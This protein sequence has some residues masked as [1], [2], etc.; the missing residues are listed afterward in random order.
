MK[1]IVRFLL[2]CLA[3]A[4]VLG[5]LASPALA[6]CRDVPYGFSPG[7]QRTYNWWGIWEETGYVANPDG[8]TD[9]NAWYQLSVTWGDGT[10]R[11]HTLKSATWNWIV[12]LYPTSYVGQQLTQYWVAREDPVCAWQYYRLKTSQVFVLP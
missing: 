11:I 9:F 8:S 12:H 6:A 1:R 2:F 4:S 5:I 7:Y 3:V 10:S